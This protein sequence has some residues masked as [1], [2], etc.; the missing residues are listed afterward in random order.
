MH[1]VGIIKI[2]LLTFHHV[3]PMYSC[4]CCVVS[5]VIRPKATPELLDIQPCQSDQQLYHIDIITS[6][7]SWYQNIP[8]D[9]RAVK[10]WESKCQ[11]GSVLVKS[12]KC[13]GFWP[14]MIIHIN[15]ILLTFHELC[16]WIMARPCGKLPSP[17][18][19][20]L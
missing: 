17:S 19:R 1:L 12:L 20:S 8:S 4:C 11:V 14:Y 7:G 13:L 3:L 6:L 18:H 5:S 15:T 16:Q 10:C 2:C 9:H